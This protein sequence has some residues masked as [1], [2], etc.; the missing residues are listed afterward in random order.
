MLCQL[1]KRTYSEGLD[2][3]GHPVKLGFHLCM[4]GLGR[5]LFLDRLLAGVRALEGDNRLSEA[6]SRQDPVAA[7]EIARIAATKGAMSD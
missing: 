1:G 6:Q 5:S 3:F 4:P 2:F 7:Q